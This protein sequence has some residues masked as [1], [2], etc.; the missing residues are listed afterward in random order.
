[1]LRICVYAIAKNEAKHVERFMKNLDEADKVIV[2]V[3]VNSTD[4]TKELLLESGA[5]VVDFDINP[6]RFDEA[7]NLVL[8]E[9]PEDFDVCVSLDLDEVIEPGWRKVIEELWTKEMT[10]IRYKYIINWIDEAQTK[11]MKI[12]IGFRIHRRKNIKY[13]LPIHEYLE[14]PEGEEEVEVFTDKIVVK[15]YQDKEKERDYIGMI[16][17]ALKIEPE[18]PWLWYVRA[19]QSFNLDKLE[20]AIESATKFLEITKSYGTYSQQRSECCRIIGKSIFAQI[21]KDKKQD[22]AGQVQLWF[23]RA[24][25]EWP[26]QRENWVYLADAWMTIGNYE[27][28]YAAALNAHKCNDVRFSEESESVCWDE[29]NLKNLISCAS[30]GMFPQNNIV[31]REQRRALKKKY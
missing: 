25:S 20:L 8:N 18:K 29:K 3:D 9:I 17:E 24:V 7:R 26:M 4:N 21:Y 15:H 16:D 2:G 13:I 1:M 5:K 30:K 22:E 12:V 23:L 14:L 27:S 11:P 28:A 19:R 31:N 10:R 6:F